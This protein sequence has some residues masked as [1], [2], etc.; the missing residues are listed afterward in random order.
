MLYY[1]WQQGWAGTGRRV[2]F[3]EL[4]QYA[5][6]KIHDLIWDEVM[7]EPQIDP[8]Q[9]GILDLI[10]AGNRGSHDDEVR[11]PTKPSFSYVS[12]GKYPD[13]VACEWPGIKD[14]DGYVI[15]YKRAEEPKFVLGSVEKNLLFQTFVYVFNASF[16]ADVRPYVDDK[17]E[18]RLKAYNG[19]GI[20]PASDA[21]DGWCSWVEGKVGDVSYA[22][23][24]N[25]DGSATLL[26]IGGRDGLQTGVSGQ[27][28]LPSEVDGHQVSAIAA[29]A[30]RNCSGITQVIVPNTVQS[31]LPSTFS[32][33]ISLN[34]IIF[35]GVMP[36]GIEESGI[37]DYATEVYYPKSFA[38]QYGEVVPDELFAG[39]VDDDVSADGMYTQEVD[40]I[41]WT[42]YVS[43]GKAEI[44][45][46][47]GEVSAISDATEGELVIPYMLGGCPVTSIGYRAFYC[48]SGLKGVTI[49]N[50]VTSIGDYAFYSCGGLTSVTIPS[51]V[52][53]IGDSAFAFCS[54]L[55]SVTIPEGVTSIG[56]G[57]FGFCR[58][59]TSVTIPNSVTSIEDYAFY[60]CSG[61]TSVTIPNSVTSI[62]ECA[63]Y[64]CSGLTL[65]TIPDGVTCIGDYA[66][67]SCSGLMSVTI[68]PSVTSI[69]DSAFEDCPGLTAID[70]DGGNNDYCSI[71]GVLYNKQKTKL[72]QCPGGKTGEMSIP[73][74]VTSIGDEA[75]DGCSGLTS[76]TMPEGVTSIGIWAFRGS[77]LTSVTIPDS[78]T[79]IA[80]GAFSGCS[81]LT[82]V[83]IPDSVTSIG[84]W[85]FSGCISLTSVTI[86]MGVESVGIWAF[87][88]SGLTSVTIPGSVIWIGENAFG[89]C[90]N[91]RSVD[92]EGA[93]SSGLGGAGVSPD[94]AIRYNQAYE[95]EWLPM[96]A[97]CGFTNATPYVPGGNKP[98]GGPYK[99]TVDGI[100]WTFYV[101]GGKAEIRSG[102]GR[103]S[104]IY[105]GAEGD[106]VIPSTLGGCPVMS[107]G[108]YAFSFCEGLKSVTIQA[109]VTS[110]GEGAFEECHGLE[111][112]SIPPTVTSIGN[113]AFVNC[114]GLISVTIPSG[115][116]SIGDYAFLFCDGLTSVTIPSSVT[117]IGEFAF[118]ECVELTTV[119][120]DCGD[121]VRIRNLMTSSGFDCSKLTFKEI[122]TPS[123]AAS[124]AF[125]GEAARVERADDSLVV[126][127]DY[128]TTRGCTV[129]AAATLV[130]TNGNFVARAYS[131]NVVRHASSQTA[132]LEFSWRDLSKENVGGPYRV[133]YF[134]LTPQGTGEEG[135]LQAR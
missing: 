78:L 40:G 15:F 134:S 109:G 43:G 83:T 12:Q 94:V 35:N 3:G 4:A 22:Y 131:T 5:Q 115:V 65:V 33:C 86:P 54:G 19:A 31:L 48:C 95:E 73:S 70:V 93:P 20:S 87:L 76:V 129:V 8:P 25:A 47:D 36:E 84:A 27:L 49:P 34:T 6:D 102:D 62:G 85:A 130:D 117:S 79:C 127:F 69:G 128:E 120:V 58:G 106:I 121:G 135:E 98:D 101:S 13:K 124:V 92:F 16:G 81:G 118:D 59:L 46:G 75:F 72:I 125:S 7:T 107:I 52:T 97:A 68:P 28:S 63:F 26:R 42:F 30:L 74:S 105:D 108:E 82:S 61:L 23:N 89:A 99:E 67:Y 56:G 88:G 55:T 122:V 119:Y 11:V 132:R 18:F 14:T 60:S 104:A 114:Y 100:E 103:S 57:S 21:V 133:A 9:G 45:S 50:S 53:S 1:G 64:S 38:A 113:L 44:R 110:I 123:A 91:L 17:C 10:P 66:F 126:A 37:L 41:E 39:Y 29:G 112:V 71:D 96:I 90:E 77:G 51:T 32:N 80:Y 2:T 111:S 24:L 116:I